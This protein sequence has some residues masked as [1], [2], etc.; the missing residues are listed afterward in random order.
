VIYIFRKEMKK[1]HTVLWVVFASLAFSGV[2]LIF[3]RQKHGSE[4]RVASVN[5][6]KVYFNDYRRSLLEIQER[7][8]ALRPMA[9]AYGM[10]EE[11]F[12]S[13][14]LG[15]TKPEELALDS[16]VRAKLMDGV[17]DRFN[18]TIDETWFKNE[19][20]KTMP[21]LADESG[22]INMEMYQR[23]LERLSTKPSEYEKQRAE[24]LKREIVQ[25]FIQGAV[26]TPRFIAQEVFNTDNVEK[27]FAIFKVSL[28]YFIDA[29]KKEGVSD[30][31]L[32][33][34]YTTHKE[35]YRI[36]EKRKAEYW[37]I[38]PEE[39]SKKIDIDDQMIRNF[40]EKNK[41][42][43][44]RIPPKVKVRRLLIKATTDKASDTAYALHK[45]LVEK[46]D[47]FAA[48]AKQ[49]SQDE[50]TASSG[51]LVDFFGK[52]T[53]DQEFERAAF[54]LKTDGEIS[55]VVKTKAGYEIIQLA[56]RIQAA[57]KPLESVKDD[58][59]KTLRAKR[60]QSTLRGDLETLMRNAREDSKVVNQF[61]AQ[62]GLKGKE[63]GWL[64][65]EDLKESGFEGNIAKKLFSPHKRQNSLGYFLDGDVYILYQ[66]SGTEK[67]FI[68]P[69][70]QVK[71]DVT[72][73][74]YDEKAEA[75][76][77]N[78][79]KADRSA[80]LDRK[81]TLE[82]VADKY[83]A[84]VWVTKLMGKVAASKELK[85]TGALKDKAFALTDSNQVLEHAHKGT[86]YLV[87]VREQAPAKDADLK[88]DSARIIKQ[89]KY[90]SN[91]LNV[92]AFIASLHRNAK[93]D[94]DRKLI[95][96][97]RVDVKD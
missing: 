82:Q 52:G 63:T 60:T 10:S 92:G 80:L 65:E 62:N 57:E 69:L 58:I 33:Q 37:E 35:A 45:Q 66:L 81:M 19:L 23:Y 79:L 17:K 83:K 14:F 72:Q 1:W 16:C 55:P 68:P 47:T 71:A 39:F 34:Y 93:I 89:E 70:A 75:L 24:E 21:Q 2:S 56:Q 48:T 78:S 38:S 18:I 32:E 46:P 85:D 30:A 94:I 28:N 84:S 44:F 49:H 12:L 51:G 87:Q 5:G 15:A 20:I 90:K 13:T 27:S 26:Y 61:V 25:R 86:F 40:Y 7:I 91:S 76:A 3:L 36:G 59:A 31:M 43:L 88:K 64:T 41:G 8:N 97:Q 54:R 42:T 6:Y 77:R 73:D 74:Y 22:R 53:Y 96:T 11:L 67:S 95:E 4:L 50:K 29:V 9:R